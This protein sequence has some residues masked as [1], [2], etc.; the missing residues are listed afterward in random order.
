MCDL[1]F[2]FAVV[3]AGTALQAKVSVQDNVSD[4]GQSCFMV[5]TATA[6][7]YYQKAG[8]G[9]SSILDNN[10]DDWISYKPSGG[11]QGH[12]RGIPNMGLNAFGHPGYDKGGST[13]L[14]SQS[15]SKVVLESRDSDGW[16]VRWE[17]Y[18]DRAVMTVVNT[19]KAYWFLYEGTPG[20]RMEPSQDFYYVPAASETDGV[21]RLG[22]STRSSIDLSPEWIAFG[23]PQSAHMLLLAHHTDD[24]LPD[25]YYAMDGDGGMTVFGFGRDNSKADCWYC[26]TQEPNVFTIALVESTSPAA[27]RDFAVAAITNGAV[28]AGH[29]ITHRRAHATRH[30]RSVPG[31]ILV[32]TQTGATVVVTS[33][34]GSDILRQ[35]FASP[36]SRVIPINRSGAYIVSIERG[37]ATT[38][39]M[40][41]VAR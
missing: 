28:A 4:E 7:Y 41:N 34:N 31:G 29:P 5:T 27:I 14:V 23:D 35:T 40:V 2:L 21:K 16:E 39:E 33:L 24:D 1:R 26:M 38:R 20:G 12:Y 37:K 3:V 32:D 11:A 22:A 18:D 9:F 17:F 19:P 10:G 8:C 6:T 36:E 30:I 13:T 15:E 25:D